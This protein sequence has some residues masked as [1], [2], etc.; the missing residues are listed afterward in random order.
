MALVITLGDPRSINVEILIPSLL[1]RSKFPVVLIGGYSQ[2]K[3][4]VERLNRHMFE[5]VRI[6]KPDDFVIPHPGE[7]VFWDVAPQLAN[8]PTLTLSE[9]ERGQIAVSALEAVRRIASSEKLAVLTLPVDKSICKSAGF[10]YPGQTEFFSEVWQEA[11]IMILAGPRLRVALA[12]N[13]LALNSVTATITPQLITEKIHK[14]ASSL[15]LLWHIENPRIAV[16]GLNPHCGD[17]GMFGREDD[18]VIRPAILKLKDSSLSVS[19]PHPADTVFHRALH[20]E[21]DAVL[22]MYHDQGL[23]PLKT[24]HFYDAINVSGGLKHL[25]CSPDHGPASELYM[26]GKANTDSTG[27]AWN[28]CTSYLRRG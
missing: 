6:S 19:G 17:R 1:E 7:I 20:G 9:L 5:T 8:T 26:S 28:F 27:L 3:E 21:F 23:G 11:A 16:C 18:Q 12:T 14:L 22:A 2:F 10:S 13:H 25:R 15:R 24:V 4:Q